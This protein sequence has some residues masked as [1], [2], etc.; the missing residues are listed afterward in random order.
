MLLQSKYKSALLCP[1]LLASTAPSLA[2]DIHWSGFASI[3]GGLMTDDLV[4]P[5]F[6]NLYQDKEFTLKK[7]SLFALQATTDLGEGL[8]TALQLVARGHEDFDVEARWAY[9]GYQINENTQ[10]IAGRFAIPIFK[11]SDTVDIGFAR[12]RGRLPTSV[13]VPFDFSVIEGLRLDY[14]NYI[15]ESWNYQVIAT[16]GSWDGIIPSTALTPFSAEASNITHLS[17][18]LSNEWL[19][20]FAGG[21]TTNFVSEEFDHVLVDGTLEQLGL[22][23]ELDAIDYD[24]SQMYISEGRESEYL[25]AGYYIDYNGYINQF[26]WT[27][28]GTHKS[29]DQFND[30]WQFTI[31]K[32]FDKLTVL[33]TQEQNKQNN[34][35]TNFHDVEDKSLAA[36]LKVVDDLFSLG[37]EYESLSL[38]F[39]YNFHEQANL[40]MTIADLEF[41][42]KEYNKDENGDYANETKIISLG[43]DI[44]F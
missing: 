39:H 28:Y 18:E 16:Y 26:E 11:F 21:M 23:D 7:E 31:G 41:V 32:R 5:A 3:R 35:S 4:R 43:I 14:S 19:T 9:I 38:N 33:L 17:V 36:R 20:L 6:H 1:V 44:V 10:V 42:N 37:N 29:V 40:T 13:Y 12:N 34:S 25:M 15:N 2:A 22:K 30:G 24:Y 8:T 27:R